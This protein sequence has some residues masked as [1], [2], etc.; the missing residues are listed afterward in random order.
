MDDCIVDVETHVM[1]NKIDGHIYIK[2]NMDDINVKVSEPH[3]M[4][5]NVS[6]E[7]SEEEESIE[8]N[9]DD[10]KIARFYDR[11]DDRTISLNYSFEII[12]VY[13]SRNGLNKVEIKRKSYIVKVCASMPLMKKPFSYFF[14]LYLRLIM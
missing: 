8:G 2:H 10:V 4:N 5:L 9:D 1:G 12:E 13:S 3:C 11:D 7:Q 14:L 6:N